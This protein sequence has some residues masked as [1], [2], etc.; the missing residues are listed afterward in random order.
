MDGFN[1]LIGGI[2]ERL[3]HLLAGDLD[4]C[5]ETL[6]DMSS[7]DLHL[8]N[9]RSPV[10]G[11]YFDLDILSGSLT[12]AEAVIFSHVFDDRIVKIVSG[13]LERG[14][15]NGASEGYDCDIGGS[16][17]DVNDHIAAGL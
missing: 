5:G 11:T 13:D 2:F 9:F 6:Y 10:A 3:F 4:G 15:L 14:A 7:L 8:L 1:D 16:S 17:A 12:Y